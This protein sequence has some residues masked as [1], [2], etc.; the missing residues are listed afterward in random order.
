[1]WVG[2]PSGPTTE[3]NP[4]PAAISAMP[5]VVLPTSWTT[6]VIVPAAASEAAI[7]SGMRS[8]VSVGSTITNCPGLCLRAISGASTT[9]RWNLGAISSLLMILNTRVPP[10]RA[11]AR[12]PHRPPGGELPRA[13]AHR[14]ARS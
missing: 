6:S 4:S 5:I 2:V 11:C 12:R 7:V 10:A 9:K 8:P 1:M 3:T 14:C 13:A